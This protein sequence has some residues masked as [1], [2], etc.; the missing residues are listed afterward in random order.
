MP[1]GEAE[2]GWLFSRWR[3]LLVAALLTCVLAL[4]NHSPLTYSDSGNYLDNARDLL[5]GHRPWFFFRPLTYGV[6]LVP[7]A[8]PVTLWLL[9]VAQGLLVAAAVDLALRS[10][11]VKLSGRSLVGLFAVLSSVTSL[12][13]FSG[14]IMPDIFTPI[15]ILLS[16]V[17]MWAPLSTE[18]TPWLSLA[19]LSF[20]IAT[21]LSHFPLYGILLFGGLGARLGT[22]PGVRSW[23]RAWPLALRTGMPLAV[24]MLIVIA[25]NYVF[26]RQAVLSRS[27]SL[28]VLAHLVEVGAAQRYLERACPARRYALCAERA[29]L[30][31]DTDWFLWSAAG[32][33]ARSEAAMARGDSTFLRE[34]PLIV[35]GAL[36]QEWPAV[37]ARSLRATAKQ[38]VT[39]GIHH[40]EHSFSAEVAAAMERLSPGAARAYRASRQANDGLPTSAATG[41]HYA[42]V[43]GA[44]LALLWCLPRMSGPQ[45]RPFRILVGTVVLGVVANAAILATLSTVHPRYESRVI[46]LVV[47]AGAVAVLELWDERRSRRPLAGP[48]HGSSR[49]GTL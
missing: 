17:V 24:A 43:G 33:R 12:S 26:H 16:F 6:F 38:L 5:H 46:W 42:S 29:E 27:S 18:R 3:P 47:L 22:D 1:H 14:Q 4:Y 10:A 34:A 9:P 8:N 31:A 36:R 37:L 32:P 21:H 39:F 20:A 49:P 7:F 30:R 48:I 35:A 44:L 25:P 15:L 19:L 23:R 13:W 41:L 11:S 2:P 40:G 28:F 45:E